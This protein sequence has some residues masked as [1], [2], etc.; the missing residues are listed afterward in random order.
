MVAL[1][2]YIIHMYTCAYYYV[3]RL[4]GIG[5]DEWVYDGQGN[6]YS[7]LSVCVCVC[8]CV[9]VCACVCVCVC[10]HVCVQGR[11]K[12]GAGGARAPQIFVKEVQST[13]NIYRMRK[14]AEHH[15]LASMTIQS[16]FNYLYRLYVHVV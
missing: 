5:S 4:I 3:S 2:L 15:P 14:S 9:C 12:E 13:P 16:K 6:R 1:F 11:R 7:A 10:V 8:R